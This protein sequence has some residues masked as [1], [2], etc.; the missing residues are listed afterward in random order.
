MIAG[1]EDDSTLEL[2]LFLKRTV[3]RCGLLVVPRTGHT[4][5]LEEPAAFNRALEAFLH[6]VERD[7][8]PARDPREVFVLV[9]GDTPKSR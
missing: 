4:I 2:A 1:D 6:T 5:N 7:R 9:P 8:W 3:A